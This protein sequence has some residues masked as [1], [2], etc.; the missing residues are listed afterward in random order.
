VLFI[1]K[2]LLIS[3]YMYAWTACIIRDLHIYKREFT[4]MFYRA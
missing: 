1:N 4:A 2:M 3:L